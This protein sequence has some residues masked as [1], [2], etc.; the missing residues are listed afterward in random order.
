MAVITMK[1][2]SLFTRFLVASVAALALSFSGS[3]SRAA[4]DPEDEPDDAPVTT[5]KADPLANSKK[6]EKKSADKALTGVATRVAV[7]NFGL[8][9]SAQGAAESTVGIEIIAEAWRDAVKKLEQDKVNVVV[10]RINSGGGALSEMKPFQDLFEKVYKTKFRTVAWVESA[11]SCAAMSPWPIGDMY[12]LPGGKIGACTAWHQVGGGQMVQADADTRESILVQMEECSRWANRDPKIMRAMQIM[13]PLS[14]NIDENGN[15]KFFQD[16]S[17]KIILNQMGKILTLTANEALQVGFSKGTAATL[18]DLMKSM[19]ITE[20]EVA[21]K[22][23]TNYID[24]NIKS[25]DKANKEFD[26]FFRAYQIAVSRAEQLRGDKK[27]QPEAISDAKSALRKMNDTRK[28]NSKMPE[29]K[30]FPR[31][32]FDQ[33]ERLLKDLEK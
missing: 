14:A 27:R 6:D 18:D 7:L 26:N 32:W 17:G 3:L 22:S 10:V 20:Y 2:R 8:P 31:A 9:K 15:V 19:G 28:H 1:T 33:Q 11:I 21:G 25:N 24:D 4:F 12:F 29:I 5:P 16:L 30:G 23:A 13:E